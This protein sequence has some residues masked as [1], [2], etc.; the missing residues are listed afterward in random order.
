MLD[1][2]PLFISFS[3]V[4]TVCIL[5]ESIVERRKKQLPPPPLARIYTDRQIHDAAPFM[6]FQK[7]SMKREMST[8]RAEELTARMV[9]YPPSQYPYLWA[10]KFREAPVFGETTPAPTGISPPP[11]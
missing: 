7:F 3:V 9:L 5:G 6:K 8:E 1:F 4:F 10:V 2:I 11:Q